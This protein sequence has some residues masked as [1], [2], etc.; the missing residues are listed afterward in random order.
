MSVM[1]NKYY[2]KFGNI[3][4]HFCE[5]K[6]VSLFIAPNRSAPKDKNKTLRWLF[7]MAELSML[8]C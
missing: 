6:N 4:S 7:A 1:Q 3:N 8:W 5:G 2:L